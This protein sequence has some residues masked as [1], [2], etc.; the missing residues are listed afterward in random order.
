MLALFEVL[1]TDRQIDLPFFGHNHFS[2]V[3]FST[4]VQHSKFKAPHHDHEL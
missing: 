2:N 3:P 4:I 1:P